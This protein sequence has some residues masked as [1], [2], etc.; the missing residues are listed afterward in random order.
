MLGGSLESTHS[1]YAKKNEGCFFF[2][3]G[4][5]SLMFAF[6]KLVCVRTLILYIKKAE[7]KNM[8]E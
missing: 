7:R 1:D 6:P 2:F 3:F 5:E 4:R 8:S